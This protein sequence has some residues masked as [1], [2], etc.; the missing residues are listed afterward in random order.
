MTR[1]RITRH[2]KVDEITDSTEVG[3]IIQTSETGS[4]V[5]TGIG[6]VTDAISVP[7]IVEV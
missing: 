2:N 5:A 7:K 1:N 4:G 3:S 6:V